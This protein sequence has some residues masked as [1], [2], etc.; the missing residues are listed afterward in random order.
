V[1]ERARAAVLYDDASRPLIL[2]FK[3]GDAVHMTGVFATWLERAGA[4]LLRDA[5]LLMPVPLHRGRL[6]AR[7]YNQAALLAV[8]LSRRTGIAADVLSLLRRRGTPSQGQGSRAQRER[9]VRGAFALDGARKA[10]VTGRR[11]L[12]VDDVLASGATVSACTRTLRRA[13]A[14]AV[15]V[16]T[17]A[18]VR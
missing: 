2:R 16:L 14:A 5:D 4:E 13:G 11:V 6:F 15:D 10:G 3:H 9:N 18:R 17:I 7:R 8:E 1:F 12:L